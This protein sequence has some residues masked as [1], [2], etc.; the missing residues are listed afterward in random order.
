MSRR[1]WKCCLLGMQG[2]GEP[3]VHQL[4]ITYFGMPRV[5]GLEGSIVC[6][7]RS[8]SNGSRCRSLSSI[9]NWQESVL[10]KTLVHDPPEDRRAAEVLRLPAPLKL[11]YRGSIQGA[12]S[13]RLPGKMARGSA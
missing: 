9:S 10:P 11:R 4:Q 12:Y 3:G 1:G 8:S 13:S 2:L 7:I 5:E 6:G